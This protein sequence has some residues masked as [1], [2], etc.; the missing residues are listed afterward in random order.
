[1]K[2]I[3][4]ESHPGKADRERRDKLQAAVTQVEMKSHTHMQTIV[5]RINTHT[6]LHLNTSCTD[7][8]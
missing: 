8:T 2:H 1:M 7:I 3:T 4:A 5:M 6:E